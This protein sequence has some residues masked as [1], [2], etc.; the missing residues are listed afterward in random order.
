MSSVRPAMMPLAPSIWVITRSQSLHELLCV[1]FV[2]ETKNTTR[3]HKT[4]KN[5]TT[6][7][8]PYQVISGLQEGVSDRNGCHFLVQNSLSSLQGGGPDDLVE[9]VL[10]FGATENRN[11]AMNRLAH[12]GDK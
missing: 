4:S 3:N 1:V 5:D 9:T 11:V 6:H 12:I 8:A 7:S 2:H 10:A